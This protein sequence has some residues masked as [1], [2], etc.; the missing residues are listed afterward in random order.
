MSEV[1]FKILPLVQVNAEGVDIDLGPIRTHCEKGLDECPPEDRAIAWLILSE[2]LTLRPFEWLEMRE[3]LIREYK[4][5]VNLFGM[6]GYEEK[7]FPNTA[8][9]TEFGLQDDRLMELIH[10]DIVRTSHHIT[11]MPFP[12]VN[13]KITSDEP[14]EMLNPYHEHMRKL[15]RILYIFAKV[16][17]TIAYMQG[18]NELCSVIYFAYSSAIEYFRH[19]F[20]E[21][22]AFVFYTFQNLLAKTRIQELFTTQDKSSLIHSQM[23]AFMDILKRHLPKSHE[24]I[25]GHDIHPLCFCFRWLNLLFAQDYLMPNLVLIW[26][27]IFSHFDELVLYAQYIAVAQVKMLENK[28]NAEDYITTI[29]T[30]QKQPVDDIRSLLE[31]AHQFWVTDHQPPK[32]KFS[33]LFT[34]GKK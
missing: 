9:P 30:L 21:V 4:D 32:K 17:P 19:N 33:D 14:E 23:R 10:G 20:F 31:Y 7:I 24:I 18:F 5:F 8:D 2:V 12:D 27:A 3:Q 13:A 25:T 16:N 28:L 11:F 29:T 15:E 34:F 22:E 26:D 6:D 1:I